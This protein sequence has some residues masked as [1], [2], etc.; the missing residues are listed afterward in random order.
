MIAMLRVRQAC[1]WRVSLLRREGRWIADV[2]DG[3]LYGNEQT[4][5]TSDSKRNHSLQYN[6]SPAHLS[7]CKLHQNSLQVAQ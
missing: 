5:D 4:S 6:H 1:R 2:T 3:Q 7:S